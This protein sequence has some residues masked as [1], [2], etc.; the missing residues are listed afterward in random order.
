MIDI[1]KICEAQHGITGFLSVSIDC[2]S[3]CAC[4]CAHVFSKAV[5][6]EL[7]QGKRR[8]VLLTISMC[9]YIFSHPH[10]LIGITRTCT[11]NA[12]F[13]WLRFCYSKKICSM[14]VGL[15]TKIFCDL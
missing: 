7:S 14:F 3:V 8:A 12:W 2:F 11:R 9:K 13:H 15:K 5:A 1:I 10:C 6:M 4:V